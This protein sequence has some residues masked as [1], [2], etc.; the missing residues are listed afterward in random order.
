MLDVQL[1]ELRGEMMKKEK[2]QSI[3]LLILEYV[4]A[5]L[6]GIVCAIVFT[7]AEL[8]LA[9]VQLWFLYPIFAVPAFLLFFTQLP[10]D[11]FG[12]DFIIVCI[13]SG[14]VLCFLFG[15]AAHF[16][17]LRRYRHLSPKLIG[18]NIGF[19]GTLAVYLVSMSSI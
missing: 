8:S 19:M 13:Y 10:T 15:I 7:P 18:F 14:S 5:Y 9:G 1:Y 16:A 17:S 6:L 4:L 11:I 12:P 3:G 2:Q